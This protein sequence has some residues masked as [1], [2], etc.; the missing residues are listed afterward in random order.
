MS[1]IK[2]KPLVSIVIPVFNREKFVVDAINS[3]LAQT[4]E[5]VEVVVVDNNSTD[6]TWQVISSFKS[7]KLRAYRNETNIG[8]V[9][10][11]KKGIE[12]S[13]GDYIKLLFS[14]DMISVNFV[15]ESLRLFDKDVAFVLS[16]DKIEDNGNL[17]EERHYSKNYYSTDD[18]LKK[19]Y[20]CLEFPVSPGASFFRK[21]DI[22]KAFITEI[23]TMGELDPMKNGAGVDLLIYMVI[24][25]NY[26][27]IAISKNSRAIFRAHNDS[28]SVAGKD[29]IIHYYYRAMIYYL[30]VLDV[31]KY[32]D[33]FKISM[34]YAAFRDSCFRVEYDLINVDSFFG[35]RA[36]C[37]I[38]FF[39]FQKGFNKIRRMLG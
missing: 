11:W 31:R 35:V 13:K 4:Y 3:A 7:P 37:L 15:E 5:N 25:S 32:R 14:D 18:Y 19:M 12:L 8:P 28:F 22:E 39:V 24:A 27:K 30:S 20:S 29:Y 33:I 23:P 26:P 2:N 17:V 10:N 36:I 34:L 16:P 6:N 21:K 9:L 38:P 1:V